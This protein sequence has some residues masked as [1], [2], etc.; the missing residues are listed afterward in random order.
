MSEPVRLSKRVAALA[1]CSRAKAEQYIQG[2]WVRVDGEVIK[3]PHFKVGEQTVEIDPQAKLK[4]EES[5]TI[6]FHKPA[7]A[8]LAVSEDGHRRAPF[9]LASRWSEDSSDVRPLPRHLQGL[10]LLMPLDREVSGLV[11]LTQDARVW[12]R[13]SEDAERV[14]QEYAVDFS[15]ALPDDA[16]RRLN[17]GV[18]LWG[19]RSVACKASR[20]S[21]TRL[22]LVLSAARPG[23][24]GEICRAVGLS[25][26]GIR[27]LRIGSVSLGKMPAGNWRYHDTAKRF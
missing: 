8:T 15:G 10:T 16:L 19:G 12:R 3:H 21:D 18:E 25:F 20:Q 22:R 13:L 24:L 7:G 5:I 2:G 23:Q 6:L 4:V 27:R 1:G 26:T 11:A 14:E 9:E 17:A